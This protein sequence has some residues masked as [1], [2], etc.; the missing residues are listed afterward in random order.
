MAWFPAQ[1]LAGST[2]AYELAAESSE[3]GAGGGGRGLYAGEG[4]AESARTASS[5]AV[6]RLPF[7]CVRTSS[8]KQF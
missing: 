6:P 2:R 3:A 5:I 4:G 1:P 8:A 7:Q